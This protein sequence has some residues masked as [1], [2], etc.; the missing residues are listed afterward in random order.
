MKYIYQLFFLL[1]LFPFA[2]TAQKDSSSKRVK[3]PAV[4]TSKDTV[5]NKQ[6]TVPTASVSLQDSIRR[7]SARKVADSISR[8]AAP[9]RII[10]WENDT[11]YNKVFEVPFLPVKAEHVFRIDSVRQP[12]SKDE[13]FYVFV[14]I[15]L[16]LG[17]IRFIFPKYFQNIFRLFFQ[18]S[19]RQ[20]QTREQLLQDTLP[21]LLM[22]IFFV[23]VGGLLITL[24]SLEHHWVKADFW[25]TLLYC[26]GLLAGVYIV[27]YLFLK[28]AGWVFNV[29]DAA[30]T[31]AFIVFL[32]NKILGVVVLPLL[33][34]YAFSDGEVAKTLITII[35]C[36]IVLMIAYRYIASLSIIRNNLKVSALQFFIYLCAVEMVPM[37]IIY[38]VLFNLIM[39]NN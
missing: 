32:I 10:T 31:Y 5:L 24:L 36:I 11:L 37:M 3:P 13:L 9:P 29:R 23:L 34:F 35:L 17:F 39:K 16:F 30:E 26:S 8:I 4:K 38:K 7:D 22:N 19:F 21:S 6:V 12:Q 1:L 27:K 15:F 14:G 28:F 18:T 2:A 25:Q 33:L 20:K